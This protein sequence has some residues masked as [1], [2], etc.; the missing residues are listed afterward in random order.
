ML[1][2]V[3]AVVVIS[4]VAL[5]LFNLPDERADEGPVPPPSTVS[6]WDET[7]EPDPSAERPVDCDLAT[8]DQ[9]PSPPL[10]DRTHGGPLSFASLAGDWSSPQ[11]T[12]RFPFSRD[13]FVQTQ[14]IQEETRLGWESSAQVGVVEMEDFPGAEPAANALL[15]CLMTSDFYRT[16]EVTLAESEYTETTFTG[17]P[18]VRVDALLSFDHPQLTTKGSLVRI[19]VVASEPITYY[20]HAVP[21]E[22][23]DLIDELDAA[24]DSLALD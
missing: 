13:A 10:D 15:Q 4:L 3:A 12:R 17:T 7:S 14:R 18:A 2:G 21:E 19:I 1:A 6:A 9:L 24:T 20:F 16:I 8:A 23:T 11:S 5:V 22:S